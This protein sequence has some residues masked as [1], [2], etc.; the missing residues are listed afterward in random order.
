MLV[1][2]WQGHGPSKFFGRSANF[3]HFDRNF[4]YILCL[5]RAFPGFFSARVFRSWQVQWARSATGCRF[6][7]WLISTKKQ[8]NNLIKL[9]PYVF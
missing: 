8:A 9:C 4:L 7:L 3:P 1:G 5:A 6:M 2:I